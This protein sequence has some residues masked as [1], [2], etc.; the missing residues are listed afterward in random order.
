MERLLEHNIKS[1]G[2]QFWTDGRMGESQ[3]VG[4]E[5]CLLVCSTISSVNSHSD[6]HAIEEQKTIDEIKSAASMQ[7]HKNFDHFKAARMYGMHPK[8]GKI[9][10]NRRKVIDDMVRVVRIE[11]ALDVEDLE[12]D[13]R[14]EDLMLSYVSGEKGKDCSDRKLVTPWFKFLW[15]TYKPF[16]KFAPISVGVSSYKFMLLSKKDTILMLKPFDCWEG[17]MCLKPSSFA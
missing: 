1:D 12:A 8:Y 9:V 14:P 10:I 15:E 4:V 16:L 13:K 17:H 7:G 5:L 3:K 11:D 2:V 6:A